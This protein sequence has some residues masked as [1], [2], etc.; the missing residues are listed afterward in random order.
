MYDGWCGGVA[1]LHKTW[2]PGTLVPIQ[3]VFWH[4]IYSWAGGPANFCK[5]FSHPVMKLTAS[6]P[7]SSHPKIKMC[8]PATDLATNPSCNL[9]T[10]P[11]FDLLTQKQNR[12]PN[13]ELVPTKLQLIVTVNWLHF[14][15]KLF[16]WINYVILSWVVNNIFL[17]D[18]K[19]MCSYTGIS[20]LLSYFEIFQ[21]TRQVNT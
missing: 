10:N 4:P 3:F 9:A 21:Y 5:S 20:I 1:G 14:S 11:P 2:D 12:S 16:K 6:Q 15:F 7:P 17:M 13:L 8:S 19:N 18:F